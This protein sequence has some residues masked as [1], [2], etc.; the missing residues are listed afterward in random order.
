MHY[1]KFSHI[2]SSNSGVFAT[3][4]KIPIPGNKE[5]TARYPHN[6]NV[7]L[8]AVR[9]QIE[10][11]GSADQARKLLYRAQ[12]NNEAEPLIY[13]QLFRVE[14]INAA[15]LRKRLEITGTVALESESANIELVDGSAAIKGSGIGCFETIAETAGEAQWNIYSIMNK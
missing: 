7:W 13:D 5:Y 11:N 1:L 6:V 9:F 12:Q 15:I 3:C 2:C 10:R 4:A 14:L 8:E